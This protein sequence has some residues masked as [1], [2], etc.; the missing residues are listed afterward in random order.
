[1][2]RLSRHFAAHSEGVVCAYRFGSVARGTARA[3]SDFDV[4]TARPSSSS[5]ACCATVC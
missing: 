5:T 2:A 4:A 1:M 3:G